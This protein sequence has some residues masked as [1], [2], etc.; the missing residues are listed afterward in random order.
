MEHHATLVRCA[1]PLFFQAQESVLNVSYRTYDRIGVDE[2][3]T[4]TSES[5]LRPAQ[6]VEQTFVLRTLF[7]THEAQNALLK[8]FEEPPVGL[9]FIM[10][11]PPAVAVLPTLRSR[12]GDEIIVEQKAV[13]ES[14][15]KFAGA[16][17]AER[18]KQIDVWQKTKEPQWL[19]S[20]VAGV[21][22]LGVSEVPADTLNVVQLVGEKLATRGASNKMLL[23]HLALALPLRKS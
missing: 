20:I 12:F 10:V 8:L 22:T 7:V 9:K 15:Q 4:I 5:Q 6:G 14:W 16:T 13:D 17:A 1:E 3:K 19:Q 2:V 18:L 23:E 11:L 21:H